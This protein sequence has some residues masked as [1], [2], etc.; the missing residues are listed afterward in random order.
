MANPKTKPATK[1]ETIVEETTENKDIEL[2]VRILEVRITD[3]LSRVILDTDKTFLSVNA[4]TG[5]EIETKSFGIS[6]RELTEQ[7][8][9]NPIIRKAL[10]RAMGKQLNPMLFSFL[11]TGAQIRIKRVFHAAGEEMPREIDGNKFYKFDTYTTEF[12]VDSFVPDWDDE[13]IA[14]IKDIIRNQLT[15]EDSTVKVANFK[16]KVE[17][18]AKAMFSNIE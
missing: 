1:Q 16:N 2:L 8:R 12:D 13:D 5:E 10:K 9:S 4:T 3:R 15:I 17:L 7:F 6:I 11:L 18:T 14:D